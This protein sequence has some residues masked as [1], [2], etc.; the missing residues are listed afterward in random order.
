MDNSIDI[1]KS[2]V[3]FSEKNIRRDGHQ[4]ELWFSVVDIVSVLTDQADL[5]KARKYWNKLAQRL[6]KEGS[7]VVT[8][9]HQLKLKAPDGEM[10]KTDCAILTA[11]ISK[12]TFGM[13]PSQYKKHK[14]IAG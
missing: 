8:N 10:R 3:V 9:C 11:E 13:T 6:R 12:A 1:N 7:E 2:I 4:N 5:L 14:S